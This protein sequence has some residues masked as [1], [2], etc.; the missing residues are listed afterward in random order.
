[1]LP[2]HTTVKPQGCV[3]YVSAAPHY[4]RRAIELAGGGF[5]G[6]Q[7]VF[8]RKFDEIMRRGTDGVP[9]DHQPPQV[10]CQA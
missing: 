1:M 7:N 3:V 9:L 5:S 4:R 10:P 2:S 8:V 6:A